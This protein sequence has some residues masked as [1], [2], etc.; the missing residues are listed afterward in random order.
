M[1]FLFCTGERE[2]EVRR[3]REK[4]AAYSS[5]KK[6]LTKAK[7]KEVNARKMRRRRKRR[8]HRCLINISFTLS[9]DEN[10]CHLH[11]L[12]YRSATRDDDR[13]HVDIP[14]RRCYTHTHTQ[15]TYTTLSLSLSLSLTHTINTLNVYT[16]T[17][18]WVYNYTPYTYTF[19]ITYNNENRRSHQKICVCRLHTRLNI[20][21]A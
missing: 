19:I 16:H 15:Y 11:R 20:S 4:P 10:Q 21:S 14:C 8:D 17:R 13:W 18:R 5:D 7:R 9:M 2:G 3:E 1:D 12:L 6:S